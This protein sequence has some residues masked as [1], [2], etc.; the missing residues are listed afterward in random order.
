MNWLAFVAIA[1]L[2]DSIRIFIDNY[3]SDVYFKENGAVSQKLF[4]GYAYILI[5]VIILFF[6]GFDFISQN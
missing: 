2:F 3:T 4:Y 6:T 5:S 1:T